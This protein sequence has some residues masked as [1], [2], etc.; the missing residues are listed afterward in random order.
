MLQ[1]SQAQPPT[2][3]STVTVEPA[4]AGE[5]GNFNKTREHVSQP[6]SW[7]GLRVQWRAPLASAS[8]RS[9]MRKPLKGST[10]LTYKATAETGRVVGAFCCK[11][12]LCFNC[13]PFKTGRFAEKLKNA[14]LENES[15]GGTSTF[16]TLTIQSGNSIEE[17]QKLL[18]SAYRFFAKEV[19][20]KCKKKGFQ[21]GISYS[22]DATFKKEAGFSTHLHIHA[23]WFCSGDAGLTEQELFSIWER[24]VK[25]N[26][27]DGY[28]VSKD[29]FYAKPVDAGDAKRVS[30]YVAKFIKSA[31]EIANSQAKKFSFRELVITS[32]DNSKAFSVYNEFIKAFYGLHYSSLG[33]F[34]S[35]LVGCKENDD[36]EE[37]T[38]GEGSERT[39]EELSI[40]VPSYVHSILCDNSA[41]VPFLDLMRMYSE[42]E[43][44]RSVFVASWND[45]INLL[46][47]EGLNYLQLVLLVRQLM[48][49][50]LGFRF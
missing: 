16:L 4:F 17:Q 30:K 25:R 33:K 40:T 49:K 11:S 36:E 5:R 14:L 3:L 29:A 19:S 27:H 41:I 45:V 8:M 42:T 24:A 37:D 18:S 21:S 43:M 2:Y 46:D 20:R 31:L 10:T 48:Y 50:H 38:V 32:A 1:T 44:L 6:T 15:R 39:E 34:A 9:C 22:Y 13:G 23:I 47:V 35:S 12:P 28:Y 26:S 7:D